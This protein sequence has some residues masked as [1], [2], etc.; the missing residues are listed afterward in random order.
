MIKGLLFGGVAALIFLGFFIP[1]FVLVFHGLAQR[2]EV[3]SVDSGQSVVVSPSQKNFS[4]TSNFITTSSGA[5]NTEEI[6][7]LG[8]KKFTAD[9]VNTLASRE[10]GLSYR[11]NLPANDIMFFVFPSAS[12]WGIWMKAMNFPLDIFWLDSSGKV[13]YLKQNVSPTTYPAVFAPT[14]NAQALYVIE[15]NA[16]TAAATDITLGSTVNFPPNLRAIN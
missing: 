8:G 7:T 3:A 14:S 6:V 15:A 2:A 13:I 12:N 1:T 16:G 10:L 9:I 4:T 5:T 11:P